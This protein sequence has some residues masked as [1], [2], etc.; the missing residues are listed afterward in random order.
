MCVLSKCSWRIAIEIRRLLHTWMRGRKCRTS[1]EVY[2]IYS[3]P[4][5][6]IPEVSAKQQHTVKS[7]TIS[8]RYTQLIHCSREDEMQSEDGQQQNW[9]TDRDAFARIFD[10]EVLKEHFRH[11]RVIAM[12]ET[13]DKWKELRLTYSWWLVEEH[14]LVKSLIKGQKRKAMKQRIAIGKKNDIMERK[15]KR[16]WEDKTTSKNIRNITNLLF[17]LKRMLYGPTPEL[18]L[19]TW[20]CSYNNIQTQQSFETRWAKQD[21]SKT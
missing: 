2:P 7:S 13:Y 6:I 8:K 16:K 5:T 12:R 3:L 10:M 11:K 19:P 15:T 18:I 17:E 4:A 1:L 20:K 9:T 14:G 21:G